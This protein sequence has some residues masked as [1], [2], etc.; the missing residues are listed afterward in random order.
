MKIRR[1]VVRLLPPSSFPW[2]RY[3]AGEIPTRVCFSP[4]EFH[5]YILEQNIIGYI[6]GSKLEIRPRSDSYGVLFEDEHGFQSWCHVPID[7]FD[8]FLEAKQKENS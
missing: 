7:I 4:T 3:K 6:E 5:E 1:C 8:T 2:S